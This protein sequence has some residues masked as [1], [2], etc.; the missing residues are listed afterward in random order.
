MVRLDANFALM[1]I[2]L[3]APICQAFLPWE[4]DTNRMLVLV[5][6]GFISFNN[7]LDN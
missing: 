3:V 1:T 6:P 2:E 7:R 4:L 5:Q